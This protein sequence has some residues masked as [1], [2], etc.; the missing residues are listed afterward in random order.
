MTV[1]NGSLWWRISEFYHVQ[2]RM[3]LVWIYIF[4]IKKDR[5]SPNIKINWVD[6]TECSLGFSRNNVV[7]DKSKNKWKVYDFTS[8]PA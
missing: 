1:K 7:L 8:N 3:L 5:I 2:C 6:F 4:N